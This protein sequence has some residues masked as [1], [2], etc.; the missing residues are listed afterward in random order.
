MLR[1]KSFVVNNIKMD[2]N[3]KIVTIEE[4]FDHLFNMTEKELKKIS[5]SRMIVTSKPGFPCRVSLEDA[6][7]NEDVILF[8]YEHH[9]VTTPYKSSGPIF[10]RKNAKK[11]KLKIN[12]ISL[13]LNHRL[14]SLRIYDVYGMMIDAKTVKGNELK[15]EIQQILSTTSVSYI[16]VHNA[17]PGCYN[18]QIIRVGR[19]V[20]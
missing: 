9:K 11:A 8:P 20:A 2:T 12:E 3:F 16:Q 6:E 13:M 4:D 5:A 17:G 15:A 19:N 10:V 1:I 7:I 18:C 14:L